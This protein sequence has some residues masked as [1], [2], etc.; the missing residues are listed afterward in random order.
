[1]PEIKKFFGSVWKLIEEF[2]RDLLWISLFALIF[3]GVKLVPPYIFKEIIDRVLTISE[4][5]YKEVFFLLLASL[6]FSIIVTLFQRMYLKGGLWLTFNIEQKLLQTT[7]KK[8]LDLHLGYH[9]KHNTGSQVTKIT[10][11]VSKFADLVWSFVNTFMPLVLQ[12]LVTALILF[13]LNWKVTV[14]Y[15]VFIPVFVHMIIRNAKKV[16]ELRRKYHDKFEEASGQIG[17]SVFNIR[18]VQDFAAE[19]NEQKGVKSILKEYL[20]TLQSRIRIDMHA[21]TLRSSYLHVGRFTTMALSTFFVFTGEMSV[22]TL[23]L[24]MTLIEKNYSNLFRIGQ[25]YLKVGDNVH[26]TQRIV[27]L[28]DTKEAIVDSPDAIQ[29]RNI[30]GNIDFQGVSFSYENGI[31]V[32]KQI[33]FNVP[34]QKSIAIVG[35]SGSGKST[36]V[37]LIFRHFDVTGGKIIVD[38]KDIRDYTKESYRKN[39]GIVSQEIELFNTT[40]LEN[41]TYGIPNATMKKVKEAT[42]MAYI[43]KFIESLPQGYNTIV[44]EKGIKLSGGQRQRIG[45]A[46][47]I[48]KNP[49]ILIFDEATSALDSKSEKYIQKS[50]NNLQSNQTMVVI[51]HRLSTIKH[52][53][54]ILV[55]DKGKVVERGTYKQ[56]IKQNGLFT[57]MVKL[58]SLGL[59]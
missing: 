50:I 10:R 11:G 53:D 9:E 59:R 42:K 17:Q 4:H 41:I 57:K 28:I 3:E 47:A 31:P 33:N 14:L 19:K 22:G 49:K 27:E 15:L 48:L 32:L 51:A 34:K 30:K 5:G 26:S 25:I 12:T 36:I 1:M 45:I 16:Q 38:G 23:V 24:F 35:S 52:V 2:R 37:K 54:E 21:M 40:I 55:L 20:E 7:H 6:G 43:G 46:R 39:L 56:L 18:T 8:L 13:Y 58:Q 29:A 44:G